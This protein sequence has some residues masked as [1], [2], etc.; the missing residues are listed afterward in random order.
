MNSSE[1]DESERRARGL[2]TQA[3]GISLTAVPTGTRRKTSGL[4]MTLLRSQMPV[5]WAVL[6]QW[7][8]TVLKITQDFFG[9]EGTGVEI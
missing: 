5:L 6:I 4:D 3:L 8:G 7:R 9:T 1:E 2:A